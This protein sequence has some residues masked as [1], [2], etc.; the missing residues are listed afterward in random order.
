[1]A[2][3]RRI[4]LYDDGDECRKLEKS[5]AQVQHDVRCVQRVAAVTA[6]FPLLAIVGAAY[7][8]I[9]QENFPYNASAPVFSLLCVLGLASLIC[10]VGCAGLLTVYRKKLSGLRKEARQVVIRYL[11]SRLGKPH[12]ATLRGSHRVFDDREAFQDATEVSGDAG[13]PS[14]I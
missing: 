4:I 1:M 11:E 14:L 6:P 10:L 9:L 2:F 3:L 8:V 7:G 5:I 12:I 13:T